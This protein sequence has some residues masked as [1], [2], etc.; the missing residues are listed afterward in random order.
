MKSHKGKKGSSSK[1]SVLGK[2]LG[3]AKAGTKQG[4]RCGA[5]N[6]HRLHYHIVFIPKYR[7]HVLE[8][9]LSVRL[10]ELF[11]ACFDVNGWG[12]EELNIQSDH[13][14]LLAQL[15]PSVSVSSC[16]KHLKGSSSHIIR[17]EFPHLVILVCAKSFWSVGYFVESVGRLNEEMIRHYIRNQDRD[18]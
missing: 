3:A 11:R 17:S 9:S 6:V 13:V 15:P 7:R 5:H 1:F 10:E 18:K 12:L 4:Y 2:P 8:G 16:V 14:H